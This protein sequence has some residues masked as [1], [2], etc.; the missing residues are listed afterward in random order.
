MFVCKHCLE[1]IPDVVTN[2]E[3]KAISQRQVKV[4]WIPPNNVNSDP[5]LLRYR[6]SNKVAGHPFPTHGHTHIRVHTHAH[7]CTPVRAHTHMCM[8][9]HM[10]T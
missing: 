4:R 3:V 9:A 5:S 7:T 1:G 2:L 6:V 10:H 8:L